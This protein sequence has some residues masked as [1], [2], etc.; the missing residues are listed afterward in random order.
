MVGSLSSLARDIHVCFGDLASCWSSSTDGV[1]LLDGEVGE[2]SILAKNS[3]I[4]MFIYGYP[5][6]SSCSFVSKSFLELS[7]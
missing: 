5:I 2:G 1:L 6:P 4:G 7:S 3:T